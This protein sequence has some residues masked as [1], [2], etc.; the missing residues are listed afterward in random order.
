MSVRA[1]L[2]L[3]SRSLLIPGLSLVLVTGA[4]AEETKG[5]PPKKG[6]GKDAASILRRV[7][8]LGWAHESRQKKAHKPV[9]CPAPP[10][11]PVA[12]P[13][14]A[15]PPLVPSPLTAPEV[16]APGAAAEPEA[17]TEPIEG[18]DKKG[19]F[20]PTFQGF[21]LSRSLV[22]S[23]NTGAGLYGIL[24][25]LAAPRS[26]VEANLQPRLK[27]SDERFNLSADLTLYGATQAPERLALINEA[28]VEA[29]LFGPVR[30]LVGR[31]RLTWGSG[32][33]VNPTD[34]LNPLKNP[35]D[36]EQQ[37]TGAFLLPLVDV[38][39]GWLTLSALVSP[40]LATNDWALPTEF[41]FQR[42][43]V[44]GRVYTLLFET[45]L[46][47]IYY[48]DLDFQRNYVGLSF[49]RFLGERLEV[50]GEA[51][52]RTG[53]PD[54]FPLPPVPGCGPAP[55]SAATSF[56]GSAVGGGR[57]HLPN[58]TFG[59]LEYYYNGNGLDSNAFG[60][61]PGALACLRASF[62]ALGLPGAPTPNPVGDPID[63]PVLLLRRHYVIMG[64]QQP[65]LTPDLFEDI[66]IGLSLI[67]GLEDGSAL[68]LFLTA[69]N[70]NDRASVGVR[71]GFWLGPNASEFNL[72]PTR[73]VA[74]GDL[75]VSF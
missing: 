65:H 1:R 22:T 18:G 72:S 63:P 38:N 26:F 71:A 3:L 46:N 10:P 58:Q 66:S 17:E 24:P 47:F 7:K 23:T 35:L 12:A 2:T 74:M 57:I 73:F 50:H 8:A 6:K 32:I 41:R 42:G 59:F 44:A 9:T 4:F 70:F 11:A 64:Y 16:A 19:A 25:T 49:S 55:Q 45:D 37:R 51:L 60:Q 13:A 15:S 20:K 5:A 31:E 28:Y 30:V 21:F 14:V 27:S 61:L 52:A 75:Q 68:P 29:R 40:H 53:S 62:E 34:L 39:L 67:V 43:L 36:V 56:T 69:Y 48:H 54:P 33:A